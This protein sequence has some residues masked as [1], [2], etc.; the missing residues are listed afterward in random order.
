MSTFSTSQIEESIQKS[1]P[2]VFQYPF[3]G[4]K[5]SE[6]LLQIVAL[7]LEKLDRSFMLDSVTYFLREF[8]SNANK[9]NIKRVYFQTKGL[10]IHNEKD[11]EAGMVDFGEEFRSNLLE[12]I[13][14]IESFGL[15]LRVILLVKDGLFVMVVQNSG[16]PTSQELQR[17]YSRI[18]KSKGVRDAAEAYMN[19]DFEGEGAGLGLMSVMLMLRSIGVS[20]KAYQF[21]LDNEKKET[22]VKIILPLQI[23][24]EEQGEKISEV[25]LKEL[26][27]LP[28]FPENI[29]RLQ[30]MM[31]DEDVDFS[32]VAKVIQT[33]PA[34]TAELLRMVN[35]A[36]FMLKSKVKSIANAISLIGMQTLK[37]LLFSYGS[38]KVFDS[39]YED[40]GKIWEHSFRTASYSAQLTGKLKKSA[41]NDVAY[42]AGMLHDIGKIIIKKTYPSVEPII[43]SYSLST[44]IDGS[45]IEN[46]T[47]GISHAK[48]GGTIAAG[49]NFPPELVASIEFHHHPKLAEDEHQQLVEIVYLAN[50]LANADE[51]WF[52]SESIDFS[53]TEKYGV[54]SYDDFQ[55]LSVEFEKNYQEEK[56][57]I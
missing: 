18:T 8:I 30:Q 52:S 49:W 27:Q 38:Q 37:N 56:K 13:G 46:L 5:E 47:M 45:I 7:F 33:D 32:K 25:I 19:M 40:L 11:Y 22:V 16:L 17:I 28:V 10:D 39:S 41:L 15:Y 2:L 34:L 44:G 43:Q 21:A 36:Q 4:R 53:V 23:I 1:Q 57:H 29:T 54:S 9:S 12:Y 14:K 55:K 50:L 42:V 31:S 24:T 35:S 51:T 3:I 6:E 20:E 48:I 26:E